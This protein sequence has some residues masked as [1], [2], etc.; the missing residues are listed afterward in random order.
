MLLVGAGLVGVGL[1]PPAA[2]ETP[3]HKIARLRAEAAHVQQTIDRMNT[4][5]EL[6]VEAYDANQQALAKTGEQQ[7][8]TERRRAA[9][10]QEL[11][12]SQRQLGERLWTVYTY[13]PTTA[14]GQLLGATT[15]Q[16]ALTTAMYQQR[17]VDADRAAVDRVTAVK[18]QLAELAAQLAA[19]RRR[20]ERL[21][22][23]LQRQHRQIEA[24]IA[25]Q[26][27]YLA[28]VNKAVKRAV[29]EERRRLEE[30]RR[31]ALL[32]RLAAERAARL[33]AAR[34]A[35]AAAARSLSASSRASC[36]PTLSL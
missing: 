29:E 4:R 30:L 15:V 6:L 2:A 16:D 7:R 22:L 32:R 36:L 33:R 31:Q 28:K 35:A 21:R 12:D 5:I 23:R 26:R 34:A 18:R 20:Q 27:R 14:L 17:V 24:G 9:A 25:A 3:R 13:G 11:E 19:Q 1:V 8:R 10:Q